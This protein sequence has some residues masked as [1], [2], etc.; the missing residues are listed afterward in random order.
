MKYLLIIVS[1]LITSLANSQDRPNIVIVLADDLDYG[2]LA[3]AMMRLHEKNELR[4]T[5]VPQ[6]GQLVFWHRPIIFYSLNPYFKHLLF[7][8]IVFFS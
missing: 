4:W 5:T 1:I 6:T 7:R 2:D 8:D 3:Y